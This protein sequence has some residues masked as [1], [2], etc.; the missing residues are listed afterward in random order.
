MYMHTVPYLFLALTVAAGQVAQHRLGVVAFAE[1]AVETVVRN[2]A[3]S[4]SHFRR[5]TTGGAAV[6]KR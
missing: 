5:V 4:R 6:A 1:L 2:D 3:L